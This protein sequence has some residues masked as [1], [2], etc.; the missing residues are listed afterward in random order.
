M[1]RLDI[2]PLYTHTNTHIAPLGQ[3]GQP[4]GWQII[5]LDGDRVLARSRVFE[6]F[7]DALASARQ[8]AEILG[9]G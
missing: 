4:S 6:S 9:L 1:I 5:T 7:A 3:S 2:Q 8:C